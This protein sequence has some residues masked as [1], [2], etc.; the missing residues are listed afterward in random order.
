MV[1]PP[2]PEQKL[3]ERR[4]STLVLFHLNLDRMIAFYHAAPRDGIRLEHTA[5]TEAL[6]RRVAEALDLAM[7]GKKWEP[8]V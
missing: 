7:A 2:A 6:L 4:D 5:Q 8:P 1:Q 3:G